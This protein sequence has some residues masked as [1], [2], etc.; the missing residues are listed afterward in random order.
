MAKPISS[1][2]NNNFTF[3][4]NEVYHRG[5]AGLM[6][7]PPTNKKFKA[8]NGSAALDSDCC[9]TLCLVVN[10][11]EYFIN[12]SILSALSQFHNRCVVCSS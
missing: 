5:S 6:I 8:G 11:T 12:R 2:T 4:C 3:P 9:P 1:S 7:G 10:Y